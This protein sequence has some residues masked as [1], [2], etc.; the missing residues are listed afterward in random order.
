MA[1]KFRWLLLLSAAFA[2]L[3]LA[4]AAGDLPTKFTNRDSIYNTRHNLT[5]RDPAGTALLRADKMEGSRNDYGEICVYCHTPH[6]AD[7]SAPV[8][9]WNRS[10]PSSTTYIT[11]DKLN[12][13]TL[14]QTVTQPGAASLPCLSCHD[15]QQAVDA[16]RNMPG[17]G[18][19]STNPDNTFLD[20]WPVPPDLYGSAHLALNPGTPGFYTSCLSCHNPG[21]LTGAGAPFGAAD[22]SLAYISTDLRNDHP[23]GVRF[24]AQNGPGTDFKAPNGTRPTALGTVLFFDEA[25]ANSRMDKAEIRLYDNGDGPEVECGSCHDPH[26]VPSAGPGSQF[27]PTFLRKSNTASTLCMTCHNK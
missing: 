25:P 19:F 2:C 27:F 10:L 6:G 11:Y 20:T 22:F 4:W 8:P 7:A 18:R 15:G 9:L 26:G 1:K 21:G 17:S 16:A 13:T 5:M 3:S 23:V 24:P 14:T 12:T